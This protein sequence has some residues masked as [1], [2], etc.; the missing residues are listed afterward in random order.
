MIGS[1]R[2]VIKS[3]IPRSALQKFLSVYNSIYD[4]GLAL[5]ADLEY[6]QRSRMNVQPSVDAPEHVLLVVVDAMRGDVI[7]SDRTPFLDSLSGTTEAVAPHRGRSHPLRR[8]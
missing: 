7:E 8:F 2:S 5:R 4:R 3:T 6:R 1:P